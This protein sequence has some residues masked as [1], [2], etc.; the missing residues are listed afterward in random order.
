VGH[1]SHAAVIL[2]ALE[3]RYRVVEAS[4]VLPR[5]ARFR[6][7]IE[8]RGFHVEGVGLGLGMNQEF[9]GR[10]LLRNVRPLALST[11]GAL[12]EAFAL[13]DRVRPDLVIGTGG[14]CSFAPML[15]AALR[16]FPTVTVPHY[17]LR[18]ANRA[19]AWFV[20][21]TCLAREAD[22]ERFPRMLRRRIRVTHTPL[23]PEAFAPADAQG[24]RG[25][26]GLAPDRPVVALVGYSGGSPE[27]TRIFADVIRLLHGTNPDAQV[28]VQFGNH[29]AAG[30]D[31]AA[32]ARAAVARPFFDDLLDVFAGCDVVVSA[33]GETTLLELCARGVP[34]VSISVPDTPIGPHIRVLAG[35]L[36]RAGATLF[37]P[38]EGL[39]PA[40]VADTITRLLDDPGRRARLG[41]AARAMADPRATD[42]VIS[43]I[44]DL[45]AKRTAVPQRGE[46]A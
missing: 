39:S 43:V 34:A 19:L 27:T 1:L 30:E 5:D 20:D 25:R 31:A 21:R 10:D 11:L 15:A 23:R 37:T 22:V 35:D 40:A 8:R 13:M 46:D 3:K 38:A 2:G 17:A 33:A 14:R 18:R 4:V 7:W 28:V 29:P 24:A 41:G 6:E 45:L 26:M 32:V 42:K 36:E 16:G 44:E 9:S 12:R